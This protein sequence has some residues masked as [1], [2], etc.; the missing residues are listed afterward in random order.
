MNNVGYRRMG[1][2]YGRALFEHLKGDEYQPLHIKSVIKQGKIICLILSEDV[3]VDTIN[4]AANTNYG[5]VVSSNTIDSIAVEANKITIVCGS[6][7]A[8]GQ[9][10]TYAYLGGNITGSVEGPRGNIRAKNTIT[11]SFETLRKWLVHSKISF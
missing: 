4:V 5:F 10:L 11:L 6:N 2:E 8:A 9:V 3:E 1:A 7:V